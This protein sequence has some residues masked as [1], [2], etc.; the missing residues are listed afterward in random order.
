MY[1]CTHKFLNKGQGLGWEQYTAIST[2]QQKQVFISFG[3]KENVAVIGR[4]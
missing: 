3:D 4:W 1:L 2:E